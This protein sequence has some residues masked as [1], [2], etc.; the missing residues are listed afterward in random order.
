MF[1]H[2]APHQLTVCGPVVPSVE[3]VQPDAGTIGAGQFTTNSISQPAVDCCV[4]SCESDSRI[5][6]SA[7]TRT[8]DLRLKRP[9]LYQAELHSQ[10]FGYWLLVITIYH[11]LSCGNI[12]PSQTRC[13]S[14]SPIKEGACQLCYLAVPH[15]RFIGTAAL[16]RAAAGVWS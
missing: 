5:N 8:Q 10:Y 16:E 15:S 9:L 14:F 6:E 1:F 4:C 7:G 13:Q 2:T 12:T 11:L 3:I